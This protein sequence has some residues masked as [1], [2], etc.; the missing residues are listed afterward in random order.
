MLKFIVCEDIDENMEIAC[1]TIV[2]TMMNY[3]VEYKISKHKKYTKK[4]K[5]EIN[6]EYDTKI[7]ILD[8]EMPIVSGLEIASEIREDDDESTIIFVTGHPEC[9]NDIFYSRLQAIDFISKHQR[10]PERLEETIKYVIDKKYRNNTFNFTNGHVFYKIK[11]KDINYIEKMPGRVKCLIHLTNNETKE[12]KMSLYKIKE[13]LG[14][15]FYQTHKACII[16]INN[17]KKIDYKNYTIYF[18]N[19]ESTTL[20][21]PTTRRELKRRVGDY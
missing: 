21:T 5:E 12:L 10:Y 6:E 9:K 17:I 1:K 7:Y 8:I 20:L 4:L 2:K 3:D 19:N 15:S 14:P 18:E 16:N 13:K 11:Y